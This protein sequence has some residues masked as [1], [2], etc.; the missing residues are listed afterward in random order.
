MDEAASCDTIVMLRDGKVISQENPTVLM[1]KTKT[2]TLEEA[3]L[4]CGN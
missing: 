2:N 4:A 1:Q 3:F